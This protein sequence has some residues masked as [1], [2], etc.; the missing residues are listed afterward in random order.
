MKKL[1]LILASTT[2][3]AAPAFAGGVMMEPAPAPAAPLA[4]APQYNWTGFSVGAQ[5]GYGEGEAETTI[6]GNDFEFDGDGELYGLRAYYDYDFGSFIL[7]AGVQY[8]KINIEADNDALDSRI[9]GDSILRLG[10]RAGIDSGRNWYYAT[11]GYARIEGELEGPFAQDVDSDGYFVGLGYE[12]FLTESITAGAEVLYHEF[13]D[14]DL[15]GAS[16]TELDATTVSLS[17]NY[18]F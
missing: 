10:L 9:D 17:V 3:L 18:R 13:D 12:V 7:G 15:D 1:T 5:L 6:Q 14:F 11:A 4:F 16:D 2:L 8:D